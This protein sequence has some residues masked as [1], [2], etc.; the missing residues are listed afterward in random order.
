MDVGAIPPKY[1]IWLHCIACLRR[2][3][4]DKAKAKAKAEIC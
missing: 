1:N 4:R 2:C 3:S